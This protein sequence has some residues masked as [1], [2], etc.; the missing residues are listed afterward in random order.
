MSFTTYNKN[1]SVHIN[2]NNK[3]FNFEKKNR[4]VT[5]FFFAIIYNYNDKS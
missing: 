5:Y 3:I 4:N 1:Y 2:K